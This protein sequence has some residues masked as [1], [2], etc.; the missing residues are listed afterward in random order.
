MTPIKG[1]GNGFLAAGEMNYLVMK[2]WEWS[3]VEFNSFGGIKKGESVV[4]ITIIS[5]YSYEF[6]GD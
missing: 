6:N 3:L 1:E 2:T 5:M 4:K